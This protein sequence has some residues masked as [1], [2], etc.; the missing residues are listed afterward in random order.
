MTSITS[1]N[2]I[3]DLND[4]MRQAGPGCGRWMMTQGVMAEGP[5]FM[6]LATRAVQTFSAF[7]ADNDPHGE[8]DF[9]VFDLAGQRLFWKID[10]YDRDLRYGSDNPA[11]PAVTI[12]VLTIMLVSEY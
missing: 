10:Y 8:H 1:A 7:G 11:D 6:L 2:R 9:G 4:A 12:R 5:E 3:R